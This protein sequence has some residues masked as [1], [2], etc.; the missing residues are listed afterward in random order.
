[1]KLAIDVMG[2]DNAP[3][4]VLDGCLAFL[5]ERESEGVTLRLFGDEAILK[6]FMRAHPAVSDRVETVYT[7]ETIDMG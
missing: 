4:A 2:G 5:N 3:A 1:M 7:T 6:D